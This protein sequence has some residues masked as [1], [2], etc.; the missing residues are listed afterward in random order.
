VCSSDL[1]VGNGWLGIIQRLFETLIKLGWNREVLQI[2]EKFGGLRIYLNDVPEN[3]YHFIEQAE[4]DIVVGELEIAEGRKK[5]ADGSA[6]IQ[7]NK[8]SLNANLSEVNSGIQQLAGFGLPATPELLQAKA[9]IEAGLTEL[10]RQESIA[11]ADSPNWV[12]VFA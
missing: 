8:I 3:Y 2:K 1:G 5:L 6:L 7:Q 10:A 11:A 4:K 9:Q 12:G